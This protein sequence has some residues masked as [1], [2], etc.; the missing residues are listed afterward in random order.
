MLP[1]II[2]SD[3]RR[4]AAEYVAHTQ[5][6]GM[7]AADKVLE[8]PSTFAELT[9]SEPP[10]EWGAISSGQDDRHILVEHDGHLS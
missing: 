9:H 2:F 5:G 1:T 8:M 6:W 10:Q 4:A 7:K 3:D